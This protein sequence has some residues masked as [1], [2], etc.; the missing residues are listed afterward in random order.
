MRTSYTGRYRRRPSKNACRNSAELLAAIS[1]VTKYFG[2]I[3]AREDKMANKSKYPP[4]I[5]YN[6]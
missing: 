3:L 5:G 2:T 6:F 4:Q 1:S